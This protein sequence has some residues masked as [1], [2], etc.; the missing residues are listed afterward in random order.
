QPPLNDNGRL[1]IVGKKKD[2]NWEKVTIDLGKEKKKPKVTE[3]KPNWDGPFM[4]PVS[5]G[6]E[7]YFEALSGGPKIINEQGEILSKEYDEAWD[8]QNIDGELW[9]SAKKGKK[10]FLTNLKGETREEPRAKELGAEVKNIISNLEAKGFKG[11]RFILE[12]GGKHYFYA[13]KENEKKSPLKGSIVVDENGNRIDKDC[14]GYSQLFTVNNEVF[15]LATKGSK[16]FITNLL[17][18]KFGEEYDNIYNPAEVDGQL[19]FKA[20]KNGERVIVFIDVSGSETDVTEQAQEKLDLLNMV[21]D[22][23]KDDVREHMRELEKEESKKERLETSSFVVSM[24]NRILQEVPESFLEKMSARSDRAPSILSDRLISKMFPQ[25]YYRA[26]KM[27]ESSGFFGFLGGSKEAP[28][29]SPQDFFMS[30]ET[31]GMDGGGKEQLNDE[32]EVMEFRE[33]VN[34]LVV[35]GM[36]GSYDAKAARWTKSYIPLRS[37]PLGPVFENTA[38]IPNVRAGRDVMLPKPLDADLVLERVKGVTKA[39]K[40]IP[41]KPETNSLGESMV[42]NLPKVEQILYTLKMGTGSEPMAKIDDQEY[43]KFKLG[44]TRSHGPDLTQKLANLPEEVDAFLTSKE[45]TK[46]SP[47]KKVMA[48][49]SYVRSLGFY[50]VNNQEVSGLKRGK[51]IEER[52]MIS[53]MRLEELRASDPEKAAEFQGRRFAGVCADFA[54]I[55]SAILRRAGFL[56]GV[57]NGLAVNGKTARVKNLHATSFVIWPDQFGQNRAIIVDGTPSSSD[58]R[59]GDMSLPTLEE[60]EQ[61]AEEAVKELIEN[62]EEDMKEMMEII[63]GGDADAI[64]QL[65]NGKLERVLNV[66]LTHQVKSN[67][68]EMLSEALNV[69]WYGGISKMDK[70][71]QQDIELKKM[72]EEYLLSRR[73]LAPKEGEQKAAGTQLFSLV[74]DFVKRF[75]RAEKKDAVAALDRLEKVFELAKDSLEPVEANAFAALVTYLKAKN[76]AGKG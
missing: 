27:K 25:A 5:V 40:E 1:V 72:M 52:M 23:E 53:E 24:F 33:P 13:D 3:M 34:E 10:E 28:P 15:F 54:E 62:A 65:E 19:A 17:G 47:A 36:Y 12:A 69:Y 43:E 16:Q 32:T 73:S 76:M 49:E 70:P 46:L 21:H 75:K 18:E 30:R 59:I 41:L 74:E 66:I 39:N 6:G 38:T 61:Q 11:V 2:G 7:L 55:T 63:K 8:P 31:S 67:H 56:A 29:F 51:S 22:P 35:T 44:F 9:F 64:L 4:T 68:V 60:R 45:F 42:R 50:D 48:I 58:V 57:T 14:D 26:N 71:G 20:K 37:K